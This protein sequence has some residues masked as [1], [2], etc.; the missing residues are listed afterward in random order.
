LDKIEPYQL[1]KDTFLKLQSTQPQLYATLTSSLDAA[2]QQ[3]LQEVVNQADNNAL[4]AAQAMAA[5]EAN[6]GLATSG[7]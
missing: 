1:F 5:I 4:F 2:E 3:V 6:G 7:V